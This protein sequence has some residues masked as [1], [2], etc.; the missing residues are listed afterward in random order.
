MHV[1]VFRNISEPVLKMV[2][3]GT[4]REIYV[5]RNGNFGGARYE[6]GGDDRGLCPIRNHV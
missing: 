3:E 5:E 6:R 4:L 2:G 1:G